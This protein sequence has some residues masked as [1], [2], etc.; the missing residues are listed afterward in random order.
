MPYA[1]L[2]FE[3]K[4][5]G[6]VA[7]CYAHNERKK[8]VYKSNPDIVP[9]RKPENY[10]LVQPK[11]TYTREVRRLIKQAG[12]KTRSNSTV[13][14][15]TLI[16]ASPEFMQTLKPPEQREYFQRALAFV[17]SKIGQ[18]NI[19]AAVVHMDERTPHMH[20]SFCPITVGKNGKP[21]LSAKALLGGKAQLSQW[22]T[23][24]HTAMSARWPDL[25][26]GISSQITQRK[27]I[28]VALF[29]T[30]TKLDKQ[31][32]QIENALANIN[33]FTAK[34]QSENALEILA[35]W[36]PQAEYF[37]SQLTTVDDYVKSLE[38][39]EK[40]TLARIQKAESKGDER[41][42]TV[43]ISMQK[44]LDEK[45]KQILAAQREAY[46][47]AQKLQRQARGQQSLLS[48]LPLDVREQVYKAQ[49]KMAKERQAK[50]RQKERDFER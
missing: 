2:R 9:E 8:E 44:A 41:V 46:E 10:H 49:E 39:A 38:Q 21:T 7:S 42:R 23:D 31:F 34:K 27:H 35:K 28:P 37:T 36:L 26:R 48:R 30:A 11:Q 16:T 5:S 12:Y 29:K 18:Q 20:L 1:I 6:G 19:I 17:E 14:V 43:R 3:K 22:Q 50:S 45:D 15:E 40:E 25:E 33:A 4:K 32:S 24:F 47:N 13:M